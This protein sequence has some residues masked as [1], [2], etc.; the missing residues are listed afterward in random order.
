MGENMHTGTAGTTFL[1]SVMDRLKQESYGDSWNW[2]NTPTATVI[3]DLAK[4]GD[5]VAALA[6]IAEVLQAGEEPMW[7]V[8]GTTAAAAFA[9]AQEWLDADVE[10]HEVGGWLRAGCWDP[11]AARQMVNVGLRPN[12]LLNEDGKPAHW[13]EASSGEEMPLALAVADSYL[14]PEEAVRVVVRQGPYR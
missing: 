7:V 13:V 14:T 11:K 1:V 8:G 10:P 9:V 3:V 6:G 5:F 4:A 2:W 12:R